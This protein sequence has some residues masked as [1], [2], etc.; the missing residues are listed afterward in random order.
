MPNVT[1]VLRPNVVVAHGGFTGAA[2]DIDNWLADDSDATFTRSTLARDYFYLDLTNVVLPVGAQVRS[3]RLTFRARSSGA[4]LEHKDWYAAVG[5][6]DA[7][8]AYGRYHPMVRYVAASTFGASSGGS[9]ALNPSGQPWTQAD[10]DNMRVVAQRQTAAAD[11]SAT[12][13]IAEVYVYVE[14]NRAPVITSVTPSG[15]TINTTRPAISWVYTD[16]DDDPAEVTEV[17]V[18]AGSGAVNPDVTTPVWSSGP[19]WGSTTTAITVRT[20][21][22]NGSAY[23]AFVRASDVGSNG[24]W[25]A[26]KGGAAFTVSITPPPAP[27]LSVAADATNNRHTLT[28]T[29][30]GT[31]P[32]TDLFDVERSADAGVSWTPVRGSPLTNTGAAMTLHD[33]EAPRMVAV[34]YRAKSRSTISGVVVSSAW[35]TTAGVTLASDNKWWLKDPLAPTLNRTIKAAPPMRYRAFREHVTFE[36]LLGRVD[37]VAVSDGRKLGAGTLAVWLHSKAEYDGILALLR[38]GRV[39]LLQSTLT[40][41]E[42]FVRFEQ[43]EMT[44]LHH[45]DAPN[46]GIAHHHRVELNWHE[47]AAPG[48]DLVPAPVSQPGGDTFT[49][50]F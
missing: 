29:Q 41:M 2:A 14:Y 38:T 25:S 37:P 49:D 43:P 46:P 31:T 12:L 16:A 36:D 13:D 4:V 24:R 23:Q 21:L 18:F 48:V 42:W 32:V 34:R 15:G 10:I 33:Y 8:T 20:D 35:V 30:G 6:A 39:L 44:L 40:G 11:G 19:I 22:T 27:T 5:V 47:M 26:W 50:T 28:I 1:V 45:S 17:K 9:W 3:V 7:A